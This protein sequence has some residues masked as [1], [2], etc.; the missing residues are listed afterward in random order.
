MTLVKYGLR[1]EVEDGLK[2]EDLEEMTAAFDNLRDHI[3]VL[4]E[5]KAEDFTELFGKKVK[6]W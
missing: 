4:M 5:N 1:V 2:D 6:I 3:Q